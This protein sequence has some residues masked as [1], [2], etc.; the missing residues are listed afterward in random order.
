MQI[1]VITDQG[2]ASIV[3][4]PSAWL[5]LQRNAK[6]RL[7]AQFIRIED[8]THRGHIHEAGHCVA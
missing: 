5:S 1:R 8:F 7:V 4:A 6:G 3:D 2:I